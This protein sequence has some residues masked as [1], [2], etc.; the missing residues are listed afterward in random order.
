MV[1]RRFTGL[2]MI[3][4][5]FGSLSGTSA[6]GVSFAAASAT[7]P[8]VVVRPVGLC[9]MTL[10]AAL[11]SAA[12][13]PQALA[14]ACTS[15]TRAV[16]PPLR[17]YSL[18]SRMP[19]LPPVEK[20]PHGRL[21]AT[22][23]PGVG[24]SVVT[25]VQSASSSSATICA[26]PVSVPCPISERAIRTTT[27]SSGRITTHALISGEPSCARTTLAPNGIFRPR[28]SPAPTAAVPMTNERRSIFGVF[29]IMAV[30]LCLRRGVNGLTHL[31]ERAAAADVGDPRVDVRVGR[32]GLLLQERRDRHDQ[33][34]LAVAALGPVEIDPGLL[35]LVQDAAV[36][37]A[38]DR[39]DLLALRR[40]DGQHAGPHRL[41]VEVDR[42]GAAHRDAAPVLGAREPDLLADRPQKGRGRT[43]VDLLGLAVDGQARHGHSSRGCV[44]M[45][46][47][48]VIMLV[49]ASCCR[50][51]CAPRSRGIE[52][53]PN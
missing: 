39:R 1:S 13:T 21:R 48:S 41:A 37:Q 22:D 25:F 15:I 16:A 40:G 45:L 24:Y 6:G 42:A 49:R 9:V 11:Q 36:G 51:G 31:L 19:R 3:F 52:S 32:S 20:L 14:A 44:A 43:D 27:V 33:P 29:V 46:R 28:V 47:L 34:R 5:S 12:G 2:P 18:D 35:H 7:L 26:S 38:L 8:Y 50:D 23:W 53:R 10:L 4:Q 17:T 30:P